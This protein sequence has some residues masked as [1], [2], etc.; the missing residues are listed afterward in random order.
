MSEIDLSQV[1]SDTIAADGNPAIYEVWNHL[2]T[3][4]ERGGEVDPVRFDSMMRGLRSVLMPRETAL[5][6]EPFDP[7]I[8]KIFAAVQAQTQARLQKILMDRKGYHVSRKNG[9]LR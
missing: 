3:T 5:L 8:A 6:D 9:G 2:A 7:S 1:P 4:F